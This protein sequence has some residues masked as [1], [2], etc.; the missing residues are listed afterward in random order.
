MKEQEISQKVKEG[1]IRLK[2]IIEVAGFPEDHINTSIKTI[3]EKLDKEKGL[4]TI[5]RTAHNASKVSDKVFSAF[6]ELEILSETL[7]QLMGLV[8]DYLPSSVEIIEPEDP[9]SDDPQA[10]TMI[11]ND[12]LARLHRYNQMIHALK[13]ENIVLKREHQKLKGSK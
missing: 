4:I 12:L 7:T 11:L 2:M 5:E 9:I 6:M 3:A 10:V 1:W 13:A 8:Y